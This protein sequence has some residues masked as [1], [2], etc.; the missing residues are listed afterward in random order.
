MLNFPYEIQLGSPGE[1]KKRER[2]RKEEKRMGR[3]IGGER[4][5]GKGEGGTGG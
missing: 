3:R 2:G 4:E 1:L 5:R